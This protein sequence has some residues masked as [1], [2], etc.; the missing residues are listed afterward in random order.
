MPV[1]HQYLKHKSV[2]PIEFVV[3]HKSVCPIE[4]AC[5]TRLL[6]LKVRAFIDYFAQCYGTI[7]YWDE[8]P[9]AYGLP[10]VQIG[11]RDASKSRMPTLGKDRG[12]PAN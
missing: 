3:K 5:R 12:A 9:R 8:N 11:K 10:S 7:P 4:F 6:A 2:C 1:F